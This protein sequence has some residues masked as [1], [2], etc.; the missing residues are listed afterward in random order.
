MK[1]RLDHNFPEQIVKG[2]IPILLN[3]PDQV[4]IV[5]SGAMAVFAVIAINEIIQGE[6]R[7]LF[8]VNPGDALFGM[9]S[10]SKEPTY[11]LIAVP[12]E[13]THLIAIEL[14]TD[15]QQD[16]TLEELLQ[17]WSDRLVG[18]FGGTE[19]ILSNINTIQ[20]PGSA[21]VSYRL[22]Q[23]HINFQ[24]CLHQLNE[25]ETQ[26]QTQRFQNQL[27]FNSQVAER[28]IGDLTAIFNPK[29]A[30]FIQE[31]GALLTAVGAVGKARGITVRPAARSEDIER[32]KD[33]LD[34]IARAS[35]FRTRRVILAGSWWTAD[36][37][38]LLAYM[39]DGSRPVA[40]LPKGSDQYEIFDPEFQQRIPVTAK[41][42]QQI[43][44]IA[45]M[46]YR[47]FPEKAMTSLDILKFA[48]KGRT[49]DIIS[50]LA[51]GIV[52]SFV[53]MITPLTTGILIEN[54]IPDANR[55]LLFE[56]GLCLLGVSFGTTIFGI[57]QSVAS[58]R[59]QTFA[60]IETQSAVWDRLLK[61]K[62]SFFRKYTIGDLQ[63]RVSAVSQIRGLLSGTILQTIFS[64]FFSFLNLGLMLV[65]SLPLTGVAVGIVLINIIATNIF[66]IYTRRK[67]Q[68]LQEIQGDLNGLVIQLMSGVSKL[69]IAGAEQRAFA[70]WS[71]KFR[72]QLQLSLSTE[73]LED[74]MGVFT[75]VLS[76]ASPAVLFSVAAILIV[77]PES[78][79]LIMPNA[80]LS[81]GMFL[82][83]NSA[84]GTFVGGA[85]SLG[86]VIVQLVEISILW[87]RA[88]PIIE[89]LPEVDEDKTDPGRL[90]GGIKLDRV[91]FRYEEDSPLTLDN[92][93]I[94]AKAGEF[95]ALVGPSGSGKS[96]TVRLLL[97]FEQP[98]DGTIYYD[99]QDVSGL[100]ITA[101]RRQLGVVLQNG[102]INSA[103]IF[104]NIS[105]GALV[106]MDETWEAARMAGFAEDIENMPM[107]MHTVISEGGT[108]L[109]GGQRQRLLIARSLVLK[110]KILIFDEATSA[111]DNR[112]Q[113]IVSESLE[114]L[115]VTRIVIAHRLS[116]IRNADRIYVIASGQVVQEGN[117]DHLMQQE[118]LFADLMNRQMV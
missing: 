14:E 49:R 15:D 20:V 92:I 60:D 112:T 79:S 116:T 109:S 81:T 118:G 41:T 40:L 61:L 103:S 47:P 39:T 89:E 117:F 33:P 29:Q 8:D 51:I 90:M 93:S 58:S 84:F 38:A 36:C 95:I 91:S 4:S 97:G 1:K 48:T 85:N 73:A 27:R 83:F 74:G 22:N 101:I 46:F 82:A 66:G 53:G 44:P 9:A 113:A 28:A 11:Q 65:Y 12:Y 77:P 104:E 69:R 56:I 106:T 80:A 100:D 26:K 57:G 10:E 111:L 96:T 94:E 62:V 102:R 32:V 76:V 86:N 52:S 68:P 72:Q 24:Y 88:R 42:A 99:G 7:F 16:H 43:S 63:G 75:S 67:M 115:E 50:I 34:A 37:G 71:G 19:I 45:Y 70:F 105:G 5:Q 35:R 13:E 3:Q 64:S 107:G 2:N 87:E 98:E 110:P 23:F 31:G 6:R 108:N 55:N 54:A 17:Q 59:L 25:Q 114:H 18:V 21:L 30:E 78:G